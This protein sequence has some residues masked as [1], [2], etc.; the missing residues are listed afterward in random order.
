MQRNAL[1]NDRNSGFRS[2]VNH[3]S[4][5]LRDGMNRSTSSDLFYGQKIGVFDF[6]ERYLILS[7]RER[8]ECRT[9]CLRTVF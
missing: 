3:Q 7:Y 9:F 6:G 5:L 1:R 4:E 8:K 2:I